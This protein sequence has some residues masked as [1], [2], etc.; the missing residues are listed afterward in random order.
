MCNIY[1][2]TGIT[3]N[4]E[5]IYFIK[6]GEDDQNNQLNVNYYRI[7]FSQ[8]TQNNN[9]LPKNDFCRDARWI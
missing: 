1:T 8:K 9:I 3:L 6:E 2:A 7:M 5:S 4:E